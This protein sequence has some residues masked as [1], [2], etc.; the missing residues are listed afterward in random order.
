M[1]IPVTSI[2]LTEDLPALDLLATWSFCF[3]L[4][5]RY[6]S[7]NISMCLPKRA[8]IIDCEIPTHTYTLLALWEDQSL[9]DQNDEAGMIV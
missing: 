4:M 5:S 6:H 3:S 1:Q 9:A 2:I 8:H 7:F